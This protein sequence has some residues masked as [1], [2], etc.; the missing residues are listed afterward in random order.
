MVTNLK[1]IAITFP[2]L[3]ALRL[4]IFLSMPYLFDVL[5][6]NGDF[7]TFFRGGESFRFI[8][9]FR[10]AFFALTFLGAAFFLFFSCIFSCSTSTGASVSSG[11]VSEPLKATASGIV[12]SMSSE[13]GS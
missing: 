13:G 1:K 8:V 10:G 11:S 7:F 5:H 6:F 12:K 4:S 3:I 2:F 9:A